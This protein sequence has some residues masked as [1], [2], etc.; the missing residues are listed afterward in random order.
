M[1]L[2]GLFFVA[3][4]QL[5][6]RPLYS[7]RAGWQLPFVEANGEEDENDGDRAYPDR[8]DLALQQ[9]AD[10]TRDPA[11]GLVPTERLLAAYRFN[12]AS[13][14]SQAQQAHRTAAQTLSNAPWVERGPSNVGGRL[15]SLLV[16][17]TDAAGNTVWAGS[18]DGGLWK[19]T[20]AASASI[21]WTNANSSFNNLAVS[22]L[23]YEPGSSPLIMYA[24]TGEGFFNIDA[25]RGAGIFKSTDGGTTWTVLPVTVSDANFLRIQKIVVHP[26]TKDVYAA[27]RTGGL[28]RSQDRGVTWTQ[29]LNTTTTPASATT[30]VTDIEIA[31]DN[32]IFA[33]FGLFNTDGIYRS[34]TGN[35]GSWTNLNTLAGSGLPTT[36]FQR[37]EVACAPSDATGVYAAFQSAA[38]GTPILD[39]YRSLDGGNTWQVLPKPVDADGGIGADYTRNQAWYDLPLAVSPTDPNTLWVGGIDLF[40]TTNG[41]TAT[42][43][44]VTWQQVTHWYGG[45]GFQN[46]HA[47]QHAMAFP[48]G[49]PNKMYYGN[50]GGFF[51]SIN[52]TVAIPTITG[53]NTG[54]NVTQFYGVAMHPTNFNY[55]LAGAQDNGTQKFTTVGVNTTS[56]ATGGDGC[57]SAIDQN[58]P[59]NQFTSYVYNSYYR[60]TDGG[61]TF[62]PFTLSSS[63]GSFINP[64]DYD[65]NANVLYA[66]WNTN[67]YLAWTNPLAA[68]SAA[69]ATK[70]T[71]ALLLNSGKVTFVGISPL[72]ANR[73]YLGAGPTSATDGGTLLRVDNANVAVPTITKIFP[74]TVNTSVSC[75]AVDPG[76]EQHLLV[77]LSNYGIVSVYETSD[78]NAA[79]PTWT[80][81]EGNLPDMP[82]RWALFDP[83]NTTRAILATEMGV[84]TTV[85]LNGASTAWSVVSN[86]P[87][88]LRVDML[89]YRPGDKLVA[90]AT[91]GRGLFTSVIF[92]PSTPLPVTLTSLTATREAKVAQVRWQT[93]SE[94]K[95]LRFEV[96][97]S[98]NAVDFQRV[99]SVA[100][101]GTST[102][103]Q[104]YS[105]P[106][107][108]AGAAA[109]YYRLKQVDTDGT[110]N[111]SPA[112][113]LAALPTGSG[114]VLSSVYPNP[115]ATEL[116]LELSDAPTGSVA[117]TM[118][119]TQGRR[120]W[121]TTA[122]AN[123][124]QLRV[125]VA[126]S[127]ARGTYLLTV[128][129]NGQQAT[130]R[131]VKE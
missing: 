20:N 110:F 8:P 85:L 78:A 42:A 119:D 58:A 105:L 15:L 56:Q 39:I 23:A 2:L 88:N 96:E 43:S 90:A 130:R 99:G 68:K 67:T 117:L 102:S 108:T 11:T 30:R 16:D 12:E 70:N 59:L 103:L 34:A 37:I 106:D 63:I 61:T 82:V 101:V 86:G 36:G 60:S 32:T 45:F 127:L 121:A 107:P 93:A 4:F 126:S 24:G 87:V 9:D 114:T 52:P 122:K 125:E 92:D 53:G 131:V 51:F 64:W 25:V 76:N 28:Y 124:R 73:I 44:N 95:A 35:P 54:L 118:V 3:A 55:F 120:V 74:G 83:R 22:A 66:A 38:A 21:A 77:T 41:G 111:Y 100:A 98:S 112:V 33:S 26:V 72:T 123:S 7:V 13:L 17:P 46:V 6:Q 27:T 129:A 14:K 84:Y 109:Y 128:Q 79:T 113:A 89:R 94:Q 50:D 49:N 48:A 69:A 47:D 116:N 104:T 57:L 75:V 29:V 1:L 81:V 18:A 97:R 71:P 80:A 115:F 19:A 65:S 62:T 31:A 91:H 10:L 40:K 5:A